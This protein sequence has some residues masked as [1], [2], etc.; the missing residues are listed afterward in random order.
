MVVSRAVTESAPR[1]SIFSASATCSDA[2]AAVTGASTPSVSQVGCAPCGGFGIDA[3]QTRRY[4]RHDRQLD[5]VAAHGGAVNP[6]DSAIDRGIVDQKT[7]LEIVGAIEDQV[8][9]FKQ[10][11][12]I[13]RP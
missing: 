3:S 7:G 10:I 4:A 6:G 8:D 1:A 2:M 13:G 11:L 9:V 12:D 5:T